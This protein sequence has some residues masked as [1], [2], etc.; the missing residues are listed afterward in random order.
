MREEEKNQSSQKFSKN[1]FFKK[2]WVFPAIYL[3]S[4]AL[5]ISMI[6]WF[7][8]GGF[9]TADPDVKDNGEELIGKTND[10]PVV[11]VNQS[12]EN[13]AMPVEKEDDVNIVTQ[14][15]DANASVEKQEE[16]LIVDGNKYR[17]S[18]GIDIAMN[19]GSEFNVLAA[20]SGKVV[21][22]RQDS[23]LGNVIEIEH[24][25]G[26]VTVYQSV[27]DF[28]V[29][30]G[31]TVKQGEVLATSSTSQLNQNAKTHVHFEVRK[32]NVALDPLSVFGQS[33]TALDSF[34]E[35]PANAGHVE[36]KAD[37]ETTSDAEES[38]ASENI[39]LLETE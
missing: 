39:E 26:I 24:E 17:A 18:M 28:K 29:K 27:K 21:T 25:K 9:N 3:V 15:F 34:E 2:R 16:A 23:L 11:E 33:L 35:Q 36:E 4:A 22:V 1:S 5:L 37:D 14:F 10:D 32:E 31:D 20:L 8:S 19:D 12:F 13:V 38:D 7:Q 30:V 6:F